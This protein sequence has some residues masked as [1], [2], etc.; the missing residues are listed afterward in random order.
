MTLETSSALSDAWEA[1]SEDVVY[2]LGASPQFDR[3]GICFA[4][5]TPGLYRSADGGASWQPAYAALSP[6]E[7]LS[8]S[9]VVVSPDFASDRTV[10]AG[11]TGAIL[12]SHDAGDSWFLSLLPSPPPV[13]SCLVAS[14][15]YERDGVLFAGTLEDG[16]F[17]SS[18]RGDHWVRWNFGLLDLHV[19]TLALSPDFAR[20]E[21]LFAGVE[22]GI[23]RSTNGGRAWRE[24][25]FPEE[26]AP[27][28]SLSISPEFRRDG[29]LLAGTEAH[30][31][32]LSR[33]RGRT[34][35]ALGEGALGGAVNAILVAPDFPQT[36]TILVVTS[37]GLWLSEDDGSTWSEFTADVPPDEA[38]VAVAAPLGLLPGAPLLLGLSNG[39]VMR[40]E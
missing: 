40:V 10:F 25:P 9:A 3:D 29:L 18:D 24:V 8:T 5:R 7:N 39:D 17:R 19:L 2:A 12:R 11:V 32:Y 6:G 38:V 4:G 35:A 1:G 27:V 15:D 23:F 28:L 16:V 13:V 30:G 26:L 34:W 33:D 37:S 22:S 31:L 21:T 36:P 14:P 20:D